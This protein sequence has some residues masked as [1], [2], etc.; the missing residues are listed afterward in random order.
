MSANAGVKNYQE[1]KMYI[2]IILEEEES[3]IA[4]QNY[5]IR[6]HDV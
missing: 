6:T 3:L 1:F 2:Y 5:P 4:A